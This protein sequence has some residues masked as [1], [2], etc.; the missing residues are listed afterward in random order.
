M[1][2]DPE[3]HH[4]RSI[5]LQ[6]FD[7]GAAGACFVTIC[8]FQRECLLG[9][10][11]DEVLIPSEAGAIIDR[12]WQAIPEKYPLV[13]LDEFIIM[14]NH[15]HAIIL[16]GAGSP[17][18]ILTDGG[19]QGGTNQGGETPPLRPTLGQVVGYF[20]YQSTKAV[21]LVRGNRGIP[22]WQRNY[23]ER[24]IRNDAE[25]NRARRYIVE[26]PLKWATDPENPHR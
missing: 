26:N 19:H 20:K 25:M 16:V 4:R 14:P 7:Y 3:I 8:S 21:N 18:P 2:F 10:I 11:T 22:I 6:G 13:E 5:R 23:Y 17:R 12:W 15:L 9:R 24:V 1:R